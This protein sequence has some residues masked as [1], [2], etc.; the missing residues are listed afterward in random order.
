MTK[1]EELLT[2]LPDKAK[3]KI[4]SFFGSLD[5]MYEVI[6][7]IAKNEHL[8]EIEKP[9]NYKVKLQVIQQVRMLVENLLSSF[10]LPGKDIVA[11]IASD[12]FDDYVK[13]IERQLAITNEQ[14]IGILHKVEN[15]EVNKW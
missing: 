2:Y 10:Q 13:Y 1:Y 3:D 6:Y 8:T 15:A 5:T 14:F 7:L 12:Y 11:D 4:D 9:E